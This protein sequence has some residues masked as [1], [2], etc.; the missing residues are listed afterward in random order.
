L[1][2]R[3]DAALQDGNR[4][5][6]SCRDFPAAEPAVSGRLQRNDLFPDGASGRDD[7]ASNDEVPGRSGVRL[8][9]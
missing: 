4:K 2:A 7:D 8:R 1:L 3:L 5:R 9:T 6:P